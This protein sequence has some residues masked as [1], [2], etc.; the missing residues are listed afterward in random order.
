MISLGSVM[1]CA[2]Y[3]AYVIIGFVLCV[4]ESMSV[5]VYMCGGEV[6]VCV[7]V[8]VGVYVCACMCLCICLVELLQL[9]HVLQEF[10]A[11]SSSYVH[12]EVTGS[13]WV[14][15]RVGDPG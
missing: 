4:R 7:D 15:V 6:D 1:Y 3:S 13:I 10:R 12:L 14:R 5:C 11:M 9:C 2:H 8:R